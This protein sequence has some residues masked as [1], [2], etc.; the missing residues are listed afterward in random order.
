MLEILNSFIP[1]SVKSFDIRESV[2]SFVDV[3]SKKV[4]AELALTEVSSTIAAANLKGSQSPTDLES[5]Y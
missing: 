1:A 2:T 5:N 4:A 3:I